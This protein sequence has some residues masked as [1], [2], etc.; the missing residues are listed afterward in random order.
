M[1]T[2][3]NNK[4]I[5]LIRIVQGLTLFYNKGK[6]ELANNLITTLSLKIIRK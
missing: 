6:S 3:F 2:S 1:F 4:K 5:K